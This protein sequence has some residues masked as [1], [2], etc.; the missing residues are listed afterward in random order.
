MIAMNRLTDITP[1]DSDD[2][3]VLLL[4]YRT[5]ECERLE[6]ELARANQQRD[7]LKGERLVLWFAVTWQTGVLI[8]SWILLLRTHKNHWSAPSSCSR[9]KWTW[10]RRK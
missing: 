10:Q 7:D 8:L 6:K 5:T 1:R 3:L 9:G 4:N 2:V